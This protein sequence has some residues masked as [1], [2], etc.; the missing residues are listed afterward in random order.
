[1]CLGVIL[2][3][4]QMLQGKAFVLNPVIVDFVEV[5]FSGRIVYVVLVRRIAR[6]VS[7]RRIDLDDHELVGREMREKSRPRSDEK[8]F[9]RRAVCSTLPLE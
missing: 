8:H 6:P 2:S 5:D 4:V 9:R 3:A 7:A 1:M